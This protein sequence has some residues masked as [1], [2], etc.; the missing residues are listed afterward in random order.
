MTVNKPRRQ[1]KPADDGGKIKRLINDDELD[2]ADSHSRPT[3]GFSLETIERFKD[4]FFI[5]EGEDGWITNMNPNF[6]YYPAEAFTTHNDST[7]VHALKYTKYIIDFRS[8][9]DLFGTPS[10][11]IPPETRGLMFKAWGGGYLNKPRDANGAVLS[12]AQ[13]RSRKKRAQKKLD[14]IGLT[15]K[16]FYAKYEKPVEEWDLEELARGVPRNKHG[17]WAG[18]QK[19]RSVPQEVHEHALN[20]FARVVKTRMNVSSIDAL[21]AL[22]EILKSNEVDE[23]GK[24]LVSPSTKA[25]VAKYLLD[26]TVGKPKQTV[27]TDISVKLQGILGVV[28]GN[29][30]EEF[31]PESSAPHISPYTVGHLPG[32]T[33]PLGTV[34]NIEDAEIVDE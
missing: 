14:K 4:E 11:V 9:P 5:K 20:V 1:K 15:P 18:V 34:E 16:E 2:Y 32:V 17:H 23:K 29:P 12:D 10:G 3:I 7:R 31:S 19:P 22:G 30:N 33:M 28:I 27:E 8:T 25:D 26:H 6:T 13:I 24:P 21:E